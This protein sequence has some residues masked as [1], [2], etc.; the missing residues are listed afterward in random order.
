MNSEKTP[1]KILGVAKGATEGEIRSA[2]RKLA[3]EYHPDVNPGD[4]KAEERFKEIAGA[5]EVLSDASKRKAYDEFGE[6]SLRGGF[7]PEQARAYN[8]WKDRRERSGRPF[9]NEY[10]DLED[11]FGGAFG[12]RAYASARGADIHA[13]AELELAQVVNGTEVSI[14]LPGSSKPTRVRIP[15]GAETGSTIRLKGRG[16]PGL[17]EGPSGDLVIETRVKPHPRV[18]RNGLDLTMRVPV[19]L[20]EA[21]SG[22]SIEVPTFSGKVK[23]TVPAGSQSGTKLRLRNKGIA[24]KE[25]KGDFYVELEL[26]LPRD[27]NEELKE[28]LRKSEA[29]YAEPVRAGLSL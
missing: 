1:Y 23:V 9:H 13:V 14:Q 29:L 26:R 24:R 28:A 16:G 27:E 8:Q 19:T 4:R 11:L 10:V 2:Y 17:G 22:A 6:D 25:K 20:S 18:R 12:G 21:Y 7:D 3:R 5:Y 15:A